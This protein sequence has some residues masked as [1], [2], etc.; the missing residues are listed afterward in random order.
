MTEDLREKSFHL[1]ETLAHQMATSFSGP[2]VKAARL[3]I[4]VTASL[5]SDEDLRKDRSDRMTCHALTLTVIFDSE[6]KQHCCVSTSC[7][8]GWL[9]P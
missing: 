2:L 6:L 7:V 5:A 4:L 9:M 8:T 1:V 3:H